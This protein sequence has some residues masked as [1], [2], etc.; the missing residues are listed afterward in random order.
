[1]QRRAAMLAIVLA[2]GLPAQALGQASYAEAF[3]DLGPTSFGT[4]G[5]QVLVNRGWEFRN[6]SQP[7]GDHAY[8]TGILPG[9][10]TIYFN[11]HAGAGYLAVDGGCTDT[12]SGG[13]M[14]AWAVL[15][16]IQNQIAGDTVTIWLRGLSEPSPSTLEVRYAPSGATGTGS[17]PAGV[18]DF[19][20]V[21][22]SAGPV[23]TSGWTRFQAPVPGPGRLALRFTG[24]QPG[25]GNYNPYVGIDTLS[26]GS[27]PPPPCNLPPIPQPGQSVTWTAAN[28]P[29]R[30]CQDITIPVGATVNIEPGVTV[31]I[32]SGHT[33]AVAGTLQGNGTAA[34][35]IV[36]AGAT[37]FPPA[38]TI[39]GGTLDLRFGEFHGQVRPL[40]RS[41]VLLSDCSFPAGSYLYSDGASSGG[42]GYVPG[43][44]RLERCTFSSSTFTLADFLVQLHDCTF[45]DTLAWLLRGY[46]DV[47]GGVTV[48]GEPLVIDREEHQQPLL[49]DNVSATGVVAP[50]S[51]ISGPAGLAVHGGD[52]LLGP[53]NA[54][55]GN[56]YPV[57]LNGGLLPDSIVPGAG[58]GSNAV[59]LS[60][61]GG[62]SRL[63]NV[64]VPYH[65]A[66]S[67][68]GDGARVTVD[69]GVRI[70]GLPGSW[71]V[72]VSSGWMRALGLPDAP[73]TFEGVNGG[74]WQG[75]S[76][77]HTGE[78]PHLED[79]IIRNAVLGAQAV[80]TPALTI[81]NCFFQNNSTGA[82]A[83]SYGNIF[84]GKTRFAGNTTGA[85][86]TDTSGLTL[87]N[88]TNPNSFEGNGA[89]INALE[90]GSQADAN[91]VW[92]NS[93]SGPQHPQNPSGTGDA[94]V[95]P[96]AGG[97]SIFPFLTSPPNFADHPP[98]VRVQ[99][100]GRDW[101]RVAVTPDFV[102]EPGQ[103]YIVTWNASD[104]AGIVSQ[105]IM[106]NPDGGY[107]TSRCSPTTSP[108][109]PARGRSR[110]PT[111]ASP[112]PP[113]S[114]SCA[115]SP[116][117][118]P[119][120]RASTRPPA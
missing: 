94:V 105:K 79:C 64:G 35:R 2:A 89:A 7:L 104:D 76:F 117:T 28:S 39:P 20:Q 81:D 95:G 66:D 1:M 71:A 17:G 14:S 112:S 42:L 85:S 109:A 34:S 87:L 98:T 75:V 120:R 63:G 53:G 6:Q 107:P 96:G 11:P 93:P 41:Q 36:L 73:I 61:A 99:A 43:Y 70:A 19:T 15:P 84:L 101:W 108:P 33:L 21:L 77:Q 40:S 8:Y 106:L 38:V 80:D 55:Q 114:S 51:N 59:H 47:T 44:V 16:P 115:L 22:I 5:P 24:Q 68:Y 54:L 10:N 90:F 13:Q 23:P 92:W 50:T 113:A 91:L 18:G 26:V 45:T 49:V 65:L 12:V 27:P 69:P 83:N 119:V 25:L 62:L 46:T 74:S 100:P 56:S 116:P 67:S 58:N 3:D 57:D 72:M 30:L 52:Y 86:V 32:D 60:G 102:F 31:N 103:K 110:S 37:N 78:A 4:L 29:Y 9:T 48:N 97:V 111:S 88:F 118:P 82:N